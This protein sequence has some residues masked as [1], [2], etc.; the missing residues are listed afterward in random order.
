VLSF[1]IDNIIDRFKMNKSHAYQVYK[2]SSSMHSQLESILKI[3]DNAIKVLK[4]SA[5]LHDSGI[6]ISYYGHHNHSFY[7]ILNSGIHGLSHRE[8]VMSAFAASMHRHKKIKPLL[9]GYSGIISSEDMESVTK[10][11]LLLRLAESFDTCMDNFIDDIKCSFDSNKVII[12]L[13][14]RKKPNV[15]IN[16]ALY[17]ADTFE[18]ITGR[19]LVIC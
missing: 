5:L 19:K 13:V 6:S 8:I 15:E 1:S 7:M 10:I 3:P 16:R 12:S 4:T 9:N 11:S 14:A 17:A 2:L 18:R